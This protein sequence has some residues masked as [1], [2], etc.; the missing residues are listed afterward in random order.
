MQELAADENLPFPRRVCFPVPGKEQEARLILACE[1]R[2]TGEALGAMA[3]TGGDPSGW[4]KMAG[5]GCTPIFSAMGRVRR[6]D[7]LMDCAAG[8]VLGGDEP[9]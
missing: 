5:I 6:G 8:L 9:V 2:F 1:R 7:E 4:W 3:R